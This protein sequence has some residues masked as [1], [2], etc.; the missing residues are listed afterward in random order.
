MRLVVGEGLPHRLIWRF[1]YSLGLAAPAV[2]SLLYLYF[3]LLTCLRPSTILPK[4]SVLLR[5]STGGCCSMQH[6]WALGSLL[7]RSSMITPPQTLVHRCV[8]RAHQCGVSLSSVLLLQKH[9]GD[10]CGIPPWGDAYRHPSLSAC[11]PD[12]RGCTC[13]MAYLLGHSPVPSRWQ[14]HV[15]YTCLK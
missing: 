14:H 10:A 11:Q 3:I 5:G 13:S 6:G 15:I 7:P 9:L 2:Y 8:D 1:G 12:T 4:L